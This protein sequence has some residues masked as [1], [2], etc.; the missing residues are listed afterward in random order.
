MAFTRSISE[1][2]NSYSAAIHMERTFKVQRFIERV[3]GFIYTTPGVIVSLVL[4]LSCIDAI[5]RAWSSYDFFPSFLLW[6]ITGILYFPII[7]SPC[8]AGYFAG[9]YI[10][11]RSGQNWLGWILGLAAW[12]LLSGAVLAI[13]GLI[14]G[15]GWRFMAFSS[16]GSGDYD[17]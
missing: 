1:A 13:V 10:A 8:V 15:I 17:Y 14:P 4:L 7:L 5:R 6:W 2:L 3:R 12:F 16:F 9:A 11:K